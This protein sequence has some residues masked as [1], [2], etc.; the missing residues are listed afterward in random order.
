MSALAETPSPQLR[1]RVLWEEELAHIR[2]RFPSLPPA[3]R[4]AVM[5]TLASILSE[6][7]PHPRLLHPERAP[8]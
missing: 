6:S 1:D 7:D 8:A 5:D 3:A 2:A 4:R